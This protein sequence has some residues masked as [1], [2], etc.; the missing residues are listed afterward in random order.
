[1]KFII[2]Y[3]MKIKLYY[4]FDEEN[5]KMYNSLKEIWISLSKSQKLWQIN[6][7]V[8]VFNTKYNAGAGHNISRSSAYISNKTP[9]FIKTNIDIYG[10]N[11]QNQRIYFTPDR[12]L[13]FKPFKKVF[14]CTYRDMFLGLVSTRFIESERIPQG[15]GYN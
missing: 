2:S 3:T 1:M 11:L 15:C 4:E 8:K 13:V 6:S 5:R 10:L 14:G 7:S 12:I 9:K